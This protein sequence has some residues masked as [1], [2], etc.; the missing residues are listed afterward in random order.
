MK[1]TSGKG[2]NYVPL[3][4]GTPRTFENTHLPLISRHSTIRAYPIPRD[5]VNPQ[6]L[7]SKSGWKYDNDAFIGPPSAAAQ[8]ATSAPAINDDMPEGADVEYTQMEFEEGEM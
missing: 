2:N 4:R 5:H 6:W 1:L 8:L 7:A 3:I